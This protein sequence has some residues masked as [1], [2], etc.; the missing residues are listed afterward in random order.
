MF[1]NA[2]FFADDLVRRLDARDT[3][4]RC[5]I[6]T[7]EPITDVDTTA[8]DTLRDLIV[9]LRARGIDVR[10]SELKG[11]VHDRV[12]RYGVFTDVM[13]AHTSR[14]TGQAVKEYLRDYGVA[15]TDWEDR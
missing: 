14:T 10:F 8:G 15:W 12:D 2:H 3:P 1:A 7:A 5:V 4:V 13:P 11:T 9:D 6:V